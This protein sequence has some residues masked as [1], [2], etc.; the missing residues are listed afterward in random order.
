MSY[1]F[2]LPERKSDSKRYIR[3]VAMVIAITEGS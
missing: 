2:V 3:V 1:L